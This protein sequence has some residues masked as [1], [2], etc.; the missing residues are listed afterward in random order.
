MRDY[1]NQPI[2]KIAAWRHTRVRNYGIDHTLQ[3]AVPSLQ[4]VLDNVMSGRGTGL[5]RNMSFEDEDDTD[6]I[7]TDKLDLE[8]DRQYLVNRR[9]SKQE[10]SPSQREAASSS[11]DAASSDTSI[12]TEKSSE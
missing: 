5:S 2:T 10:V 9:N 1:G 6:L 7:F 12:S 4:Q 3:A 11:K 8:Q